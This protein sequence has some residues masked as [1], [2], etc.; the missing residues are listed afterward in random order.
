MIVVKNCALKKVSLCCLKPGDCFLHESILYMAVGGA[1]F[2]LDNGS[3]LNTDFL[4][5][6]KIKVL[7]VKATVSYEF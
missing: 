3:Y 1:A 2:A 5:S 6:K 4:E 7:P